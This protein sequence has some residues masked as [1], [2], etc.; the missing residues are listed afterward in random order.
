M[1]AHVWDLAATQPR[2]DRYRTYVCKRC[3]KGPVQKD[4]FDTKQSLLEAAKQA[5][6]SSDCNV[7]IVK[8]IHDD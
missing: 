2:N 6:I 1:T 4:V 8:K 3:G 5:G 7:E